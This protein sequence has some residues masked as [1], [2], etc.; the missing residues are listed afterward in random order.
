MKTSQVCQVYGISVVRV[1]HLL[2]TGRIPRPNK[3]WSGDL[4][5]Q[6]DD[7]KRLLRVA[8]VDGRRKPTGK[9]ARVCAP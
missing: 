3:D 7:I 4:V 1:R 2:A 5:W 9:A 8:H 6:Q